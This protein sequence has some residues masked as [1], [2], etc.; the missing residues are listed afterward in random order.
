MRTRPL[1]V[2]APP[3]PLL[4]YSQRHIYLR[5]QK[6]NWTAGTSSSLGSQEG[7]AR[8]KIT[9][10]YIYYTSIHTRLWCWG[11]KAVQ[12]NAALPCWLWTDFELT[13]KRLC[14]NQVCFSQPD[15]MWPTACSNLLAPGAIQKQEEP[16]ESRVTW[17]LRSGSAGMLR[18]SSEW[19]WHRYHSPKTLA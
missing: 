7:S 1:P 14:F 8:I 4:S 2:W 6:G 10:F 9:H 15:V 13:C 3:P 11:H 19:V 12:C 17:S 16:I 5:L 18:T